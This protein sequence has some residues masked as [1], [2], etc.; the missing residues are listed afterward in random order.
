MRY[1]NRSGIIS[2]ALSFLALLLAICP[3]CMLEKRIQELEKIQK[4]ASMAFSFEIKTVRLNS[5]DGEDDTLYITE[6]EA[7]RIEAERLG[8]IHLTCM[9]LMV[10]V[11]VTAAGTAIY[12]WPE[13]HGRE[14]YIWSIITSSVA[15]SWQH[16]GTNIAV[17]T[18]LFVFILLAIGCIH[19]TDSDAEEF[20]YTSQ[21]K[22]SC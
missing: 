18:A 1:S 20:E 7:G 11:V 9:I 2:L 22:S 16:V 13:E 19:D 17:G 14:I 3:P 12:S 10:L 8:I 6:A 4:D 21:K 15:L 5:P